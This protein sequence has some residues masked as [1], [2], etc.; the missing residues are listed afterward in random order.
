MK[1]QFTGESGRVFCYMWDVKMNDKKIAYILMLLMIFS[2]CGEKSQEISES[3]SVSEIQ[4]VETVQTDTP[5]SLDATPA[6][7]QVEPEEEEYYEEPD[8]TNGDRNGL[9]EV[10]GRADTFYEA[11][12]KLPGILAASHHGGMSIF[13]DSELLNKE[14]IFED[15]TGLYYFPDISPDGKY[16]AATASAFGHI[17]IYSTADGSL[18]KRLKTSKFAGKPIWHP[19]GKRLFYIGGEFMKDRTQNYWEDDGKTRNCRDIYIYMYDME[20]D[21][22]TLI[23]TIPFPK[24]IDKW[25]RYQAYLEDRYKWFRIDFLR[26]SPDGTKLLF[27]QEAQIFKYVE[28]YKRTRNVPHKLHGLWLINID[29]T[30][31]K[32]IFNRIEW[33]AAAWFSD[34]KHLLIHFYA[35]YPDGTTIKK[36]DNNCFFKYNL[37]TGE[38]KKLFYTSGMKRH[39][40]ITHDDKYL[41]GIRLS[42]E[43]PV[44]MPLDGPNMGKQYIPFEIEQIRIHMGT[45][46]KVGHMETKSYLTPT[47]W[48]DKS[49]DIED[50]IVRRRKKLTKKEADGAKQVKG[51][52]FRM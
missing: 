45:A 16:I 1:K 18:F 50:V 32:Q 10:L 44:V 9:F 29:G 19:D 35:V 23:Y 26:V 25:G 40:K 33:S 15:G 4:Q 41:Y 34:S 17:Y 51:Y 31:L 39:I 24:P 22:D 48:Y 5:I 8:V 37:E 36:E 20:K 3:K 12:I 46:D 21:T 38:Y 52:T 43:Y 6:E 42:P 27:H 2:G 14:P 28:A 11:V 49:F 47:W 7:N 13:H 30:G